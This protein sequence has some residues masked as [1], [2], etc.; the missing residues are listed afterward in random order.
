MPRASLPGRWLGQAVRADQRAMRLRNEIL[1]LLRFGPPRQKREAVQRD[2]H[3]QDDPHRRVGVLELFACDAEADV[4]HPRASILRRHADAEKPKLGH[5]RQ[6]RAIERVRTIELLDAGRHFA[7]RPLARRLLDEPMLLVEIEVHSLKML[8]R[9]HGCYV[10]TQRRE[11]A[12]IS[13]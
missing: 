10:L 12:E 7:R 3:R 9:V 11:G 6:E 2:V 5:L 1:L 4:I 8:A 13:F